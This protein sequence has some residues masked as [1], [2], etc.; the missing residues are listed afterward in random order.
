MTVDLLLGS[1][2]GMWVLGQVRPKDV[3]RVIT[4]ESEIARRAQAIGIGTDIPSPIALSVHFGRILRSA[5]LDGWSAAYN[6]HPG[7]LP[8][9]RGHFPLVWA[10]W[11]EEPAG[12]TLHVMSPEVDAGPIVDQAAVEISERE[13]GETLFHKVRQAERTLFERWWPELVAGRRLP[14]APQGGMGSYHSKSDFAALRDNTDWR[15]LDHDQLIR[16]V[17]ALSFS[18]YPGLLTDGV[19]L[20]AHD[21]TQA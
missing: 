2:L 3:G 5:E 1:D 11:L 7:F 18:G 4:M 21:S 14:S 9:G 8:W 6:L 16:L 17:R 12:A 20:S 13:T 19:R 10:I 15:G